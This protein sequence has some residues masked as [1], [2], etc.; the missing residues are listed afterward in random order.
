[1]SAW[2]SMVVVALPFVAGAILVALLSA[3]L[4]APR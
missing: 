3:L 1:M 2:R 4:T